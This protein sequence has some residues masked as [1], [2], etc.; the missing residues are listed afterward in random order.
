VQHSKLAPAW[1]GWEIIG[2]VLAAQ[3]QM[4][5]EERDMRVKLES[6]RARRA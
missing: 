3:A 2:A 5:P 6:L 1:S 4:P